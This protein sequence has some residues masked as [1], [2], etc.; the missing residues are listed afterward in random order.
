M[1]NDDDDDAATQLPSWLGD[2]EPETAE[3][4]S[5]LSPEQLYEVEASIEFYDGIPPH[6]V[7]RELDIAVPGCGEEIVREGLER[8]KLERQLVK[9]Q[10]DA[11]RKQAWMTQI[12]TIVWTLVGLGVP[13]L[14]VLTSDDLTIGRVTIAVAIG[15]L[16]VGGPLA[17]TYMARNFGLGNGSIN[18]EPE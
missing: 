5:R 4:L 8:S 15:I 16:G 2:L 1:T 14:V 12:A 9:T 10:A 3:Q 11:N 17:A 18:K 7:V 13:S 6:V